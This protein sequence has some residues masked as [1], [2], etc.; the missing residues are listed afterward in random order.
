[1][2]GVA[3]RRERRRHGCCTDQQIVSACIDDT[4]C[5]VI[6]CYGYDVA[7]AAAVVC[8]CSL[9]EL[10]ASNRKLASDLRT[11]VAQHQVVGGVLIID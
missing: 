4:L 11:F 5:D 2:E 1:M 7:P 9:Q 6:G 3:E 8:V 10:A